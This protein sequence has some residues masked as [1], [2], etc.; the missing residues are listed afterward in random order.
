VHASMM[1]AKSLGRATIGVLVQEIRGC[2]EDIFAES[3]SIRR[4][5][6]SVPA[7]PI[8]GEPLREPTEV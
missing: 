4:D 5:R 7:E 2:V 6:W 1:T 8:I 3:S